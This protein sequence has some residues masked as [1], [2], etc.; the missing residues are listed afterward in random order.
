[1]LL[2]LA[3][4]FLDGVLYALQLDLEVLDDGVACTGVAI[5]GL[6][7]TAGIDDQLAADFKDIWLVGVSNTNNI[8]FDVLQTALPELQV[9]W[10]ILV[11]RVSRRGVNQKVACLVESEQAGDGQ[12]GEVANVFVADFLAGQGPRHPRE[13]LEP[14]PP[15]DVDVLRDAVV[16]IATD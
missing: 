2:D 16:V 6:A 1:G 7:D 8:G 9:W 15:T 14:V 5:P 3:H 13:I 10:R 12:P 4:R 11:Q